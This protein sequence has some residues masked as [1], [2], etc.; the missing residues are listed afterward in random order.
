[1]KT[2]RNRCAAAALALALAWA[3]SAA[4]AANAAG[5]AASPPDV[6]VTDAWARAT[7]AAA[8]MGAVYLTI[9]SATGDRLI[10]AS[11]PH[12]VAAKTQI[13]ETVVVADSSGGGDGE[14]MM[15]PVGSIELPPGEAVQFKPGGYHIML[16]NL[17]K[18]LRS[19]EQVPVTLTFEK[20]GKRKAVATVRDE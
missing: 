7:P 8:R 20:A 5:S 4:G 6:S 13:H 3:C 19:G 15:R 10:G 17:K 9:E 16:L 2:H 1:M 18:P 11:V 14:M 12:S